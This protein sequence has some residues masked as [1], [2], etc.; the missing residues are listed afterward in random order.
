MSE[1]PI[2]G[3]FYVVR[4]KKGIHFDERD[5]K[6][7]DEA[8]FIACYGNQ[9]LNMKAFKTMF[10]EYG[11]FAVFKGLNPAK[12]IPQMKA[13]TLEQINERMKTCLLNW[14]LVGVPYLAL[15][16]VCSYLDIAVWCAQ[17]KFLCGPDVDVRI[18]ALQ[19][20]RD[21]MDRVSVKEME[22][23]ASVK[24]QDE[25]QRILK[26]EE[27]KQEE[28]KE[29]TVK[30]REKKEKLPEKKGVDDQEERFNNN[31]KGRTQEKS[32]HSSV[33]ANIR[34][35]RTELE[36]KEIEKGEKR[37]HFSNDISVVEEEV[38]TSKP[39]A[40]G[41]EEDHEDKIEQDFYNLKDDVL[42]SVGDSN[43]IISRYQELVKKLRADLKEEGVKNVKMSAMIDMLQV[44]QI[45]ISSASGQEFAA[46]FSSSLDK[47]FEKLDKTVAR[48]EQETTRMFHEQKVMLESVVNGLE[49]VKQES[50]GNF[51][52]VAEKLLAM[53][54][55]SKILQKDV[56]STLQ[57][58]VKGCKDSIKTESLKIKED[59]KSVTEKL[60]ILGNKSPE[61]STGRDVHSRTSRWEQQENQTIVPDFSK[62]PP[63]VP[64]AS[65]YTPINSSLPFYKNREQK[66]PSR[67]ER[68]R[69]RVSRERS[70]S[71]S[72]TRG[73]SSIRKKRKESSSERSR[74]RSRDGGAG[75]RR[76]RAKSKARS[77]SR[78]RVKSSDRSPSRYRSKSTARSPTR[79][80]NRSTVRSPSRSRIQGGVKRSMSRER[81]YEEFRSIS[82]DRNPDSETVTIEDEGDG[83]GSWNWR[84]DDRRSY[85]KE[86]PGQHYRYGAV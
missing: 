54:S 6:I 18:A 48:V 68:R 7:P 65:Q 8:C 69:S 57:T 43:V 51:T 74:S 80:V 40:P 86:W 10:Q 47:R 82:Y 84:R 16:T 4:I 14:P 39:E 72:A 42:F 70:G 3:M 38:A 50:L 78:S 41:P 35:V 75:S 81:G 34:E 23:A 33:E 64:G 12:E 21:E 26:G 55:E 46:Q 27:E 49:E 5:F 79:S 58:E 17:N 56:I 67:R 15:D 37:V 53:S 77:P 73:R 22:E 63:T 9:G 32:S 59:V 85:S 29:K 44:K 45:D 76:E 60:V 1:N 52:D 31:N 13:L 28:P 11:L 62:P 66:I 30:R 25:E 36:R 24:K 2:S 20:A 71:R 83:D 19:A 61:S